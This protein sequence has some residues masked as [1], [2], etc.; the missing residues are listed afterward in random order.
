MVLIKNNKFIT[1]EDI[2]NVVKVYN[3]HKFST[4]MITEN[5]CLHFIGEF[6]ITKKLGKDI[7]KKKFKKKKNKKK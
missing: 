5:M 4:F 2:G 6:I 3:G 1:V 7:H